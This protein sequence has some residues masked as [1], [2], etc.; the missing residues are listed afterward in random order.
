MNEAQELQA[1]LNELLQALQ[2]V[3]QSGEVLS[4]E[5]QEEIART[6]ELLSNRIEQLLSTPTEGLRPQEPQVQQAGIPSSNVEGFAYDDDNKRLL[7]RFLGQ[8]PNRNGPIYAYNGVPRVIFELFQSGA[9]PA[10]TDGKNKWGRWWKGK[11]PS[12]GAS[13]YSLI[14]N[15][16]YPYQRL[17]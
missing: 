16:G 17:T 14:K 6:L 9:I 1:L 8:F 7:V 15:Q 5:F 12:L 10:R 3:M 11:V 4:D 13:L 2:M